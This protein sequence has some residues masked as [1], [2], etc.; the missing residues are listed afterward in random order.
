[1]SRGEYKQRR[2]C[3]P[4]RGLR[5]LQTALAA[6][7]V[8]VLSLALSY[9]PFTQTYT[10]CRHVKYS[11][12]SQ[13]K[14]LYASQLIVSRLAVPHFAAAFHSLQALTLSGAPQAAITSGTRAKAVSSSFF[15]VLLSFP[16]LTV[17]FMRN[18]HAAGVAY[19]D[20]LAYA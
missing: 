6:Q 5:Y 10:P 19:R 9:M 7:V 18:Q 12:M 15:M 14:L 2:C 1:M 17:A 13:F 11:V 3:T 16:W 4:G 8:I 20:G